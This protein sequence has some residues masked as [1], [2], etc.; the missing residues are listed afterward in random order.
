MSS[1][2][3]R[4]PPVAA[5]SPRAAR[6]RLGRSAGG[7]FRSWW[8]NGRRWRPAWRPRDPTTISRYPRS[9]SVRAESRDR[10][11]SQP[12]RNGV[13]DP[14]PPCMRTRRPGGPPPQPAASSGLTRGP[15]TH[16]PAAFRPRGGMVRS[17][18]GTWLP[19][20]C[21]EANLES[22]ATPRRPSPP[23]APSSQH[24]AHFVHRTVGHQRHRRR[25][26]LQ[27]NAIELE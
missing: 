26:T 3:E 22:R 4:E 24:H 19:S 2:P 8:R 18:G 5:A 21:V 1:L 25:R 23:R 13:G 10:G 7:P 16:P 20:P 12:A 27:S 17:F 11:R 14:L 9:P 15:E 6:R